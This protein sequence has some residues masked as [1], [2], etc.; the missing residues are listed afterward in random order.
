MPEHSMR[1]G[2]LAYPW[3]L[4][5][6]G[7]EK[8]VDT[9]VDHCGCN[10]LL[11]NSNYHSARLLRPRSAGPK[12]LQLP[13]PVSAFEPNPACYNSQAWMPTP[14]RQLAR[15]HIVES[16]QEA[17]RARDV[18]F[19]LWTVGLHNSRLGKRH[20]DLCVKNCFGDVY[21]YALCPSHPEVHGYLEGL[22]KDL[23]QQF[24]PRHLVVEAVGYLGLRHG[25]HHELFMMPWSETLEMLSS[26][27][28]CPSCVRQSEGEGIDTG[29]LH[30]RVTAWATQLMTEERGQHRPAF[31]QSETAALLLD[32]PDLWAFMQWRASVVTQLV[33]SL[34]AVAQV[35]EVSLEV[36]PASFHRPTSR[37]WIEGVSL[38]GVAAACDGFVIPAYFESAAEVSA[39]LS[40]VRSHAE[41]PVSTVL[42]AASPALEVSA[43]LVDQAAACQASECVGIYYYNY[44]L[45]TPRRLNWVAEAN[46]RLR[47]DRS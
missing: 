7:S 26:L 23:C 24:H 29:S 31:S 22:V 1:L 35:H 47:K 33:E 28:F 14:D 5:E 42:N 11:V 38:P 19:G 21:T 12:T 16:V 20:P 44:G 37:A 32:T 15:A 4:L 10:A 8:A 34:D 2:F 41:G 18:D 30:E 3:T 45:L 43:A 46:E 39:D 6:E 17:C 9:M 40:W 13:G 36:I 27:C 25:V